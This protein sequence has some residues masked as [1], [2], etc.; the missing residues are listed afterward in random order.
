MPETCSSRRFCKP[1]Y[2][3]I[4]LAQPVFL[5]LS[6]FSNSESL[7]IHTLLQRLQRC[8][9]SKKNLYLVIGPLLATA[10][11]FLFTISYTTSLLST[12]TRIYSHS[13]QN[14]CTSGLAFIS[15]MA[16]LVGVPDVCNHD[17]ML[18][19]LYRQS[20]W[21]ARFREIQGWTN[22][23][24]F[25]WTW[26]IVDIKSSWNK[27]GRQ[28]N[29]TALRNRTQTWMEDLPPGADII[30]LAVRF[31]ES[32]DR[33][34]ELVEDFRRSHD[35]QLS[36]SHVYALQ[37]LLKATIRGGYDVA[38]YRQD[39]L[40]SLYGSRNLR[41]TKFTQTLAEAIQSHGQDVEQMI[42]KA[43]DVERT[44]IVAAGALQ[45]LE[46]AIRIKWGVGNDR[47]D[48]SFPKIMA[49]HPR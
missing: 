10:C 23:T 9:H 12:T 18:R 4:Y 47:C 48:G 33:V 13:F 25:D 44:I 26:Q 28:Q 42:G 32:F 7:G 21:S 38:T 19:W 49:T 35:L 36:R 17:S 16:Q 2:S 5:P 1:G 24:T 46:H 43:R 6:A 40:R 37:V 45:Q 30:A 14:E 39:F 29:R 15:P 20:P 8:A 27:R 22:R 11:C 3:N 41:I 31:A 34:E